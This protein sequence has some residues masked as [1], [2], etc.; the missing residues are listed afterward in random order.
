MNLFSTYF[1]ILKKQFQKFFLLLFLLLLAGACEDQGCID[2]DEFGDSQSQTIQVFTSTAQTS[3]EYDST[4]ADEDQNS[5]VLKTCLL[6]SSSITAEDGQSN[7]VSATGCSGFNDPKYKDQCI[8]ACK[9]KC[10]E[11]SNASSSSEPSW[12]STDRKAN[13]NSSFGLSIDPNSEISITAKGNVQLGK[14]VPGASIYVKPNEIMPNSFRESSFSNEAILDVNKGQSINFQFS[15]SSLSFGSGSVNDINFSKRLVAYV[16]PHPKDYSYNYTDSNTL[17][18][19]RDV[20][21][22]PRF[23]G[24]KCSYTDNDVKQSECSY[25]SKSLDNYSS[26]PNPISS[27]DIMPNTDNTKSSNSFNVGSDIKRIDDYGGFIRWNGDPFKNSSFDPFQETSCNSSGDC[28]NLPNNIDGFIVGDLTNEFVYI[29]NDNYPAEISFKLIGS[30]CSNF[31]LSKFEIYDLKDRKIINYPN[32]P[33]RS[34]YNIENF[35]LDSRFKLVIGAETQSSPAGVNCGKFLAAKTLRY[36]D[37]YIKKSGFISFR[38]VDNDST[39]TS[40]NPICSLKGRIINPLANYPIINFSPPPEPYYNYSK[41]TSA[42]YTI[43]NIN[44]AFDISADAIIG[45]GTISSDGNYFVTPDLATCY[46]S[47]SSEIRY[48]Y[49]RCIIENSPICQFD[50][51]NPLYSNSNCPTGAGADGLKSS[52]NSGGGSGGGG[53]GNIPGN[54]FVN[55]TNSYGIAGES[56]KSYFSSFYNTAKPSITQPSSGSKG[57]GGLGGFNGENG[58]VKIYNCP[59]SSSCSPVIYDFNSSTPYFNYTVPASGTIRYEIVGGGGGGGSS[60]CLKNSIQSGGDAASGAKLTGEFANISSSKVANLRIYVG[61]GGITQ[62]NVCPVYVNQASFT[63]TFS[64]PTISSSKTYNKINFASYG[65]PI[66]KTLNPNNSSSS[67]N[68]EINNYCHSRASKVVVANACIGN[69][70]CSINLN[71]T[72][73]NNLDTTCS[74]NLGNGTNGQSTVSGET[75]GSGGGGGGGN[76]SL[77]TSASATGQIAGGNKGASATAGTSGDSFYDQGYHRVFPTISS[78]NNPNSQGSVLLTDSNGNS[79]FNSSTVGRFNYTV[80]SINIINYEI[81]GASGGD[82]GISTSFSGGSGASGSKLSGSF[83]VNPGD[84]LAIDI[85]E[86]GNSGIG[87]CQS[88]IKIFKEGSTIDLTIA[89]SFINAYY[90]MP[91]RTGNSTYTAN[92]YCNSTVTSGLTSQISNSSFV[93]NDSNLTAPTCA[94]GQGNSGSATI[95]LTNAGGGGGAGGGNGS[96]GNAGVGTISAGSVASNSDGLPGASGDSFY[97]PYYHASPAPTYVSASNGSTSAT[98]AGDGSVI[99]KNNNSSGAVLATLSASGESTFT[100]STQTLIYYELKGAGGGRGGSKNGQTSNPGNGASGAKITGILNVKNGDVITMYSGKAGTNGVTCGYLNGFFNASEFTPLTISGLGCNIGLINFAN[101]GTPNTSSTPYTENVS[102]SSGSLT[103]NSNITTPCIGQISCVVYATNGTFGSDPC[104]VASSTNTFSSAGVAANNTNGYQSNGGGGGGGGSYQATS[105]GSPSQPGT[106]GPS[107]YNTTYISTAPTLSNLENTPRTSNYS[108]GFS[109]SNGEVKLCDSDTTSNCQT[110]SAGISEY[111]IPSDGRFYFEISGG[112]G[113]GGGSGDYAGAT[114]GAGAGGTKIVGSVDQGLTANNKI[115]VYVGG[116]GE[117]GNGHG[118]SDS[119]GSASSTSKY[120]LGANGGDTS[121]GNNNYVGSGG[122]GGGASFLNYKGNIIALA[123]GGG[124]GGSGGAEASGSGSTAG[125]DASI[126]NTLNS[127]SSSTSFFTY[128]L[129]KLAIEASCGVSSNIYKGIGGA[130]SGSNNI[131]KGGD[132]SE[133][134]NGSSSCTGGGGGGGGGAST[135]IINDEIVAIAGGGGGGGGNDNNSTSA[136]NASVNS[137]LTTTLKVLPDKKNLY[138]EYFP[139]NL[140]YQ[141]SSLDTYLLGG[142]AGSISLASSNCSAGSYGQGGGGGGGTMLSIDNR[143]IAIAGGGGGGGGASSTANGS[144]A[145]NNLNLLDKLKVAPFGLYLAVSAEH[146][147]GTSGILNSSQISNSQNLSLTTS[148]NNIFYDIILSSYGD[149]F[150]TPFLYNGNC[151]IETNLANSLTSNCLY[152]NSCSIPISSS[153]ISGL[154]SCTPSNSRALAS[155]VYK[156]KSSNSDSSVISTKTQIMYGGNGGS[157]SADECSGSGG[158]GGGASAISVISNSDYSSGQEHFV[159]IAGGGGG[160][161]G[162]G[163]QNTADKSPANASARTA[164]TDLLVSLNNKSLGT[165]VNSF[166]NY[167]RPSPRN[168]TDE[169]YEYDSLADA[170]EVSSDP[171]KNLSVTSQAF[172]KFGGSNLVANKIFVRKGQIIRLSP[173]SWSNNWTTKNGLIRQCGIGMVAQIEPRP[174][175]VCLGSKSD[176]LVNSNCA[177]KNDSGT[178]SSASPT[179]MGC[180]P[181]NTSATT[182]C[183]AQATQCNADC[184]KKINC[185]GTPSASNNYSRAPCTIANEPEISGSSCSYSINV[186]GI[187][188]NIQS[189]CNNCNELRRQ[190]AEQPYYLSG[191]YDACYDLE[192]YTGT[193]Y[194]LANNYNDQ[195][196]ISDAFN[197]KGLKYLSKFNGTYGNFEEFLTSSADNFYSK[198]PIVSSIN[199]RMKFM[200]VDGKEFSIPS[201]GSAYENSYNNN[202]GVVSIIPTMSLVGS[203]GEWLQVKLCKETNDTSFACRGLNIPSAND[204][205][206]GNTTVPAIAELTRQTANSFTTYNYKF[207]SSG[208]LVRYTAP[209]AGKDCLSSNSMS[210]SSIMNPTAQTVTQVGSN[211]YCH[212][213]N[214]DVSRLRLSFKIFDP[215][216]TECVISSGSRSGGS[217]DGIIMNNPKYSSST[218]SNIGTVCSAS[219]L[220]SSNCTKQYICMN[221][222]SNNN[223]FY[224]VKI[225]VKNNSGLSGIFNNVIFPISEWINGSSIITTSSA[226]ANEGSNLVINGAGATISKITFASYGT[227]NTS[228]WTTSSCHATSSLEIIKNSCLYKKSCTISVSNSIFGDPCSGVGKYL[229]VQYQLETEKTGMAEKI[230][231]EIITNPA[232]VLMLKLALSISIMFYGFGYL[233][234]V[235]ELSQAQIIIRAFKIGFIYLFVS[236]TGWFW[237]KEIFV[238][239]FVDGIYDATLLMA[240]VFDNSTAIQEALNLGGTKNIG[241]LF[242]SVDSVATILFSSAIHK[243]IWAFLFTGIFGWA[244]ILIFYY[245]ILIYI[246]AL[247]NAVLLFVTAQVMISLLF[248]TGPIFFIFILFNQT[249]DMFDNWLKALLGYGLQQIFLITTLA[250]FNMLMVEVLKMS[251]SYKVCWDDAWVI[252]FGIRMTL[253]KFWTIPSLPPRTNMNNDLFNTGSPDAIPSIFSIIYIWVIASLTNKMITFMTDSA[254]VIAEGIK[255][256]NVASGIRQVASSMKNNAFRG[257]KNQIWDRTIGSVLSRADK[258]LFDSGKIAKRERNE[259]R[260][261]DEKDWKNRKELI[262]AGNRAEREYKNNPE[263]IKKFANMTPEQQ[264]DELKKVRQEAMKKRGDQIGLEESEVTRIAAKRGLNYYGTNIFGAIYQGAKQ[265]I[266]K[267]GALLS[268]ADQKGMDTKIS[269]GSALKALNSQKDY[270]DRKNLDDKIGNAD[271]KVNRSLLQKMKQNPIRSTLG[272]LTGGVSELGYRGA[273]A[274]GRKAN[275]SLNP[276]NKDFKEAARQLE[277]EGKLTIGPSY[278]TRNDKEQEMIRDRVRM[279]RD[280]AKRALGKK[281]VSKSLIK[282]SNKILKKRFNRQKAYLEKLKS[283]NQNDQ[284]LELL[285]D[286]IENAQRDVDDYENNNNPN[287]TEEQYEE[288]KNAVE[289]FSQIQDLSSKKS[290]ND[291]LKLDNIK[292]MVDKL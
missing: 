273:R 68:F 112:G 105:G 63:S 31:S 150:T 144:N 132:G 265:G 279:N 16:I 101:Y 287:I 140:I 55:N 118:G 200:L 85:A 268:R 84:N 24:W 242:S 47:I 117:G 189:N 211:F 158:T 25:G 181:D 217:Y 139:T 125:V 20:P 152:K 155:V 23:N 142:D 94:S 285:D 3:C 162:S 226:T 141:R 46:T 5:V 40:S 291:F 266:F 253:T 37:I 12:A 82:G 147:D 130:L 215:E 286:V 108:N 14:S 168:R 275:D 234:G 188:V 102:C 71:N 191:N 233:I 52:T 262:N 119:G 92:S 111:T 173:S 39:Q 45:T 62:S 17:N 70:S 146:K 240:S 35:S 216:A 255:A 50:S 156:N 179:P 145:S 38:I 202:S 277:S 106:T 90:G 22:T 282:T 236:E 81:K 128:N 88:L 224:E 42:P 235:S 8:Q 177:P 166:I 57:F 100:V 120:F 213:N 206:N 232:Y 214:V 56:G 157:I 283:L 49:N 48:K 223:G 278:M 228:S 284:N 109:G 167:I 33:I 258:G 26:D 161:G 65:L 30:E 289:Q 103:T 9:V 69:S 269:R 209:I 64:L 276:F 187:T 21:L 98:L 54:T 76:G 230:Y 114:G 13:V 292:K 18:A 15:K 93:I 194:K 36:N 222:Y 178:S 229:A 169:F 123:S 280:K 252:N 288:S 249:K 164:S 6:Q 19:P 239:I 11:Q 165:W 207:D 96:G 175:I 208:N 201:D 7:I 77:G 238:K 267:G 133:T 80:P 245:G 67:D 89:S 210:A 171:I 182:Y 138:F 95:S 149:N 10:Q 160:G 212:N 126:N 196:F 241:V 263:N 107:F 225:K 99:L 259:A 256:S 51:N 143:I 2:E 74:S 257:A 227:A 219:E 274:L 205:S 198:Y 247:A 199:G 250:F 195:N 127:G 261:K 115:Y 231:K 136:S 28:Q 29:N 186:S 110:F 260:Q 129:K 190:A 4:K 172:T 272:V 204:L 124:G 174:A 193:V 254:S 148:A 116:G 183:K 203:N 151:S 251:L 180:L 79:L 66:I 281:D 176:K 86:K 61:S 58:Q 41:L 153:L 221:K 44:P 197:T 122:A 32:F 244:Y 134:F 154:S 1:N 97:E 184:F 163:C 270:S 78:A 121:G 271:L 185:T 243:K 237:F 135:L 113:G 170:D 83:F 43:Q 104:A 290:V 75:V 248:I 53:G 73:F 87:K 159:A 246:Y 192:E 218:A 264:K 60:N 34:T 72:T 131:L 137:N 91:K 27:S 220:S 59:S